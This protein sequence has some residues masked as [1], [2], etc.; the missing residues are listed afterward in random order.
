METPMTIRKLALQGATAALLAAGALAATTNGASAYT[1]C[2]RFGECWHTERHYDY[3]A[4]LG[5]R[6]YGDG[7]RWH[8]HHYN[9]RHHHDGRGYWRNGIWIQF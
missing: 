6:F 7:W 2:N 8:R 5:V 9:W 3:P 1:V 4:R